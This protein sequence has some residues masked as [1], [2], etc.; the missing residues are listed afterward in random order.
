MIGIYL[1]KCNA[2]NKVYIGQ[3]INLKQRIAQHKY[4]LKKNRHTNS[5]LQ[6]AFNKY[7]E[8]AFVFDIVCEIPRCEYTKEKLNALEIQYIS[9]YNSNIKEKGFNIESGGDGVGRAS[10]ETCE[11]LSKAMMGK[12]V[13]RKMS[14]QTKKLMSLNS[15]KYWLGKHHSV[16]TRKRLSEKLRGKPSHLRGQTQSQEHIKK[17]TECQLGKVWVH[18]GNNSRFVSN[19]IAQQLLGEGY[20]I[21]RPFQ[22][23]VKG[24]KYEYNGGFYTIPQISEMCKIDKTIISARLRKGWKFED[25]VSVPITSTKT[26]SGRYLYNGEYLKLTHI[27]KLVNIDYEV[28]RSRLRRGMSLDEAI[29]KPIKERN[30]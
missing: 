17:R 1:I 26:N 2:N 27:C 20:I 30:K 23:K 25:A 10:K 13:G 5:Y 28:L 18:K 7:G 24:K 9:H 12:F 22:K 19:E 6:N 3:S 14:D 29:A 15:A 11:K 16:E 4:A 8:G 21:G